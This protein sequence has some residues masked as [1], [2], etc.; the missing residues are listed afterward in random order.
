MFPIPWCCRSSFTVFDTTATI[1]TIRTIG[2]RTFARATAATSNTTMKMIVSGIVM[3]QNANHTK[4][5]P[6]KGRG[7]E[8][9]SCS[10]SGGDTGLLKV[11]VPSL[12]SDVSPLVTSSSRAIAHHSGSE[13]RRCPARRVEHDRT[14]DAPILAIGEWVRSLMGW[15]EADLRVFPDV[16]RPGVGAIAV[17]AEISAPR[18]DQ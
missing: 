11:G 15:R 8:G 10:D 6:G 4:T 3:G 17:M 2:I 5:Q 7:D 12:H 18:G 9:Q 1:K 13:P 16:R 14:D